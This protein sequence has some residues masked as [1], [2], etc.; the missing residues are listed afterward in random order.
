MN[1]LTQI[2]EEAFEAGWDARDKINPAWLHGINPHFG[3]AYQ[4]SYQHYLNEFIKTL[5]KNLT[6]GC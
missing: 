4:R 2:I 3:M 6:P 5:D 1:N